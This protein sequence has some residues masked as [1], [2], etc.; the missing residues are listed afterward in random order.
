MESTFSGF[1]KGAGIT[2]GVKSAQSIVYPGREGMFPRREPIKIRGKQV[3]WIGGIV[4]PID[5]IGSGGMSRG[6]E[7]KIGI[8]HSSFE[9]QTNRF[10]TEL[11]L[12]KIEAEI[13]SK[14]VRNLAEA[15][16][17]EQGKNWS[18]TVREAFANS[19]TAILIEELKTISPIRENPKSLSIAL[20]AY[21]YRNFNIK[22]R[23]NYRQAGMSTKLVFQAPTLDVKNVNRLRDKLYPDRI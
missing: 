23:Y 15:K 8:D 12:S 5:L 13:I 2:L 20:R 21:S 3:A 22:T 10:V 4:K 1:A 19:M 16:I 11:G 7:L 6:G 9:N 18:E 17:N 14:N